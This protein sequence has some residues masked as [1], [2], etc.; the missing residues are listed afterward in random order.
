MA[1]TFQEIVNLA[2]EGLTGREIAVKLG[3]TQPAT[4]DIPEQRY[5]N[6]AGNKITR[7]AREEVEAG[8]GHGLYGEKKRRSVEKTQTEK[9]PADP[10]AG[11]RDEEISAA[12]K[13]AML[14]CGGTIAGLRDAIE[15]GNS[16]VLSIIGNL[17]ADQMAALSKALGC[18][19]AFERAVAK[20]SKEWLEGGFQRDAECGIAVMLGFAA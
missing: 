20:K 19:T 18:R 8:N 14:K 9:A 7:E 10:I 13:F 16:K 2:D 6:I 5:L 11:L 17:T 3:I 15:S 1:Y 12:A 4:S